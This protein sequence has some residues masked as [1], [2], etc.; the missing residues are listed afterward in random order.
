MSV[1]L[2]LPATYVV[3]SAVLLVFP[4]LLHKKKSHAFRPV[5]ISHRGGAGEQVENTITAFSHAVALGTD[6]LELDVHLTSDNQVVVVHDAHLARLCGADLHVRDLPY[7]ELPTLRSAIPVHFAP[8]RE[9]PRATQPERIPLLRTVFERFPHVPINIDIKADNDSLIEET[10]R[11]VEEFRREHITVCSSAYHGV[12]ERIA[13][14]LPKVP[15]FF[16]LWAAFRTL[17][18]FYSGLLPFVPLT[19]DFLE[20]PMPGSFTHFSSKLWIRAALW[21]FDH[22][23]V[24]R[25]LF[26]HLRRRGVQIK[27]WVLNDEHT[28]ARAFS[29]GATGV[30]TDYPTLLTKFLEKNKHIGAHR[31]LVAHDSG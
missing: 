27:L 22:L 6:M 16:S 10:A 21:T 17:L 26:Y 1:W 30:M 24:N 11:L 5:H 8:D 13:R 9:P 29:M 19:N 31:S 4:E 28:I 12:S 23:L 18:L 15:R 2:L 20:I 25:V 14:R 3:T 7:A